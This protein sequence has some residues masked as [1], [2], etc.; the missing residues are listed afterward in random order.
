[1]G[2]TKSGAATARAS[3]HPRWT[4]NGLEPGSVAP[5]SM[6]HATEL[7][8]TTAT[9]NS[10][11]GKYRATNLRRLLIFRLLPRA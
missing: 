10:L 7:P 9:K 2:S 4:K 6:T 5:I 1:L 8:C 11:A 3:H